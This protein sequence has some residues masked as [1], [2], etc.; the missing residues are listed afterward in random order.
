MKWIFACKINKKKYVFI[1]DKHVI[2]TSIN[3]GLKQNCMSAKNIS[4]LTNQTVFFYV[5]EF[6]FFFIVWVKKKLPQYKTVSET[7]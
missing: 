3:Q 5:V 2:L 6:R 1:N 7:R 4:Y